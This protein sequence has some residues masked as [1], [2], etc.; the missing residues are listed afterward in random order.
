M[1]TTQLLHLKNA[2][3][4][5]LSKQIEGNITYSVLYRILQNNCT[6]IFYNGES[7]IVCYSNPPYPIWVWCRDASKKND[8]ISIANCIKTNYPLDENYNIIMGYDVLEQLKK[9]DSYFENV[10]FKMELFS[11]QLRAINENNHLCD[12]HAALA[13]PA[14]LS[15]ISCMFKDM[16][17]EME[18][19]VFSVQECKEKA[20]SLINH[21]Q[22]Y[23]WKNKNCEIVALTSKKIEG[24]YGS[25]S[26]V[27]TLPMAR[28]NGYA[29]NLVHKVSQELLSNNITPILF[30]NGNYIASNDCYRKIGFEQ[31]GRICNIQR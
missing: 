18:G 22:L 30:T 21:N 15:V 5:E 17:Y 14:D 28:R 4:I 9:Y 2:S 20:L 24:K 12:G 29:I 10:S 19:L 3:N 1:S 7:V 23:V 26:S 27:Y 13:E 31:V 8:I 16:Y 25:I 11:Y 6:D